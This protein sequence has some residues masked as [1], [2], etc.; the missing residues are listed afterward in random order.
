MQTCMAV[1]GGADGRRGQVQE[2][3][4]EGGE[5]GELLTGLPVDTG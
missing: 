2:E 5:D 3:E 4:E 1:E